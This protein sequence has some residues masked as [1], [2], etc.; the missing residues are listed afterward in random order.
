MSKLR[1]V[2][3][4]GPLWREPVTR[5]AMGAPEGA[6][7]P[8]PPAEI[9]LLEVLDDGSAFLYRFTRN[10]T[11]AGDTWHECR[12]DAEA[13]VEFEYGDAVGAWA[14]VPLDVEDAQAH[15]VIWAQRAHPE[16]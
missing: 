12:E 14:A 15:A 9:V 2:A 3:Y 7:Q 1:L 4:V 16:R 5:H 11:F 13:Q 8:M 10:G 6:G